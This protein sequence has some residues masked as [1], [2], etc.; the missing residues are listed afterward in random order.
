MESVKQMTSW[1]DLH[2]REWIVIENSEMN[3]I[4]GTGEATASGRNIEALRIAFNLG[5]IELSTLYAHQWV[6]NCMIFFFFTWG[7]LN[8]A[9]RYQV[10]KGGKNTSQFLSHPPPHKTVSCYLLIVEWFIMNTFYSLSKII[11]LL[12]KKIN[13]FQ[14]RCSSLAWPYVFSFIC[15]KSV[16]SG[17][18]LVAKKVK[19]LPAMQE[20]WVWYSGLGRSPA[21]RN[22]NPLQYSCL[23][24]SR[25]RG[26][27]WA[28]VHGVAKSWTQL[29]D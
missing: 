2:S 17:T 16:T 10:A 23:E 7:I 19:N 27:W 4:Q 15:W 8:S 29:S 21:Q 13:T 3:D 24:N 9:L 14:T 26:D 25:D 20:I 12:G 18:S 28:K 11:I 1:K 22:G 6:D 5:L